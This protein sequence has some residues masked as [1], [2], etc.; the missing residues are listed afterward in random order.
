MSDEEFKQIFKAH[1]APEARDGLAADILRA[2]R[3]GATKVDATG[4]NT[5]TPAND[6]NPWVIRLG[7]L[8][9]VLIAAVFIWTQIGVDPYQDEAQEWELLAENSGFSDL[10]DWVYAETTIEPAADDP[11]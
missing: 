10:Y 4:S 6:N 7:S 9:A 1:P 2:A 8:A 5:P 11:L 3:A